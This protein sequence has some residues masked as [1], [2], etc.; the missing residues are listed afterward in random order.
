MGYLRILSAQ[1]ESSSDH[2]HGYK[3]S[4]KKKQSESSDS[5][6]LSGSVWSQDPEMIPNS[7]F[8][9]EQMNEGRKKFDCSPKCP[10]Q[11]DIYKRHP[12]K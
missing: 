9:P 3:K 2:G 11:V 10:E 5:F 12:A 6:R 1:H 4:E 8:V 7:L